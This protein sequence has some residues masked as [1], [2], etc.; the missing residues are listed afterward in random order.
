[1][2]EPHF[3]HVMYYFIFWGYFFATLA[4]LSLIFN[5]NLT[6]A[7]VGKGLLVATLLLHSIFI[8]FRVIAD[9]AYVHFWYA[10]V[11]NIFEEAT[12]LAWGLALVY[13]VAETVFNFPALGV[14]VNPLLTALVGWCAF[15]TGVMDQSLEQPP[16]AL[17]SYWI[18][19]HVPTHVIAYSAFTIAFGMAIA[20]FIKKKEEARLGLAKGF[21]QPIPEGNASN[22][23]GGGVAVMERT[24]TRRSTKTAPVSKGFY[25]LLPS[26]EVLDKMMYKMNVVG[27]GFMTALIMLGATWAEVSWGTY[28]GWDPKETSALITWLI[29]AFYLHGRIL[30]G[31]GTKKRDL[32]AILSIV[33][34]A[35]LMFTY[36]GVGFLLP[37]LHSYLKSS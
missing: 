4:Y 19:I 1:M 7:R 9:H 32:C 36:L 37:G 21:S 10:P 29:Y 33:G 3:M 28:W 20:Y 26:T 24:S 12:A 11:A 15:G 16:P 23:S 30:L 17:Q 8:V 22:L 2:P 31:W 25:A 27:F 13:L 35:A 14:F 6:L 34:F 5:Q 18:D